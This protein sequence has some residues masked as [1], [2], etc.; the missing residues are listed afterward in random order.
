[1]ERTSELRKTEEERKKEQQEKMSEALNRTLASIE[2]VEVV[3]ALTGA[4]KT[5]DLS[6]FKFASPPEHQPN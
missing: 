3:D 5:I 4:K 1:M 2:S 6:A